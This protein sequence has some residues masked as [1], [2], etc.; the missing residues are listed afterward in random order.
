VVTAGR[1]WTAQPET[2]R[3]SPHGVARAAD[4]EDCAGRTERVGRDLTGGGW[5]VGGGCAWF[6]HLHA[7]K[8]GGRGPL[9]SSN[10]WCAHSCPGA[11]HDLFGVSAA[12]TYSRQAAGVLAAAPGLASGWQV[13]SV[14][15]FPLRCPES[16][17]GPALFWRQV[18][19]RSWTRRAI[20]ALQTWNKEFVGRVC[21]PKRDFPIA[22]RA[23]QFDGS[24]DAGT[25]QRP[26]WGGPL[27][28]THPE[29]VPVVGGSPGSSG[30]RERR[31]ARLR[32]PALQLK[33]RLSGAGNVLGRGDVAQPNTLHQGLRAE[34]AGRS[35]ELTGCCALSGF[36]APTFTAGPV[37]FAGRPGIAGLSD[38]LRPWIPGPILFGS[39][40][41]Q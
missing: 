27:R 4:V 39:R 2:A 23:Q 9:V 26:A 40:G 34:S 37:F 33:D 28:P 8:I 35:A 11:G 22:C 17:H 25:W 32:I 15:F 19:S 16:G 38:A 5:W 30:S 29:P 21:S 18:G 20:A 1:Y 10:N 13:P 6:Q 31:L 3:D 24:L 41:T 36:G 12:R 14:G 7:P